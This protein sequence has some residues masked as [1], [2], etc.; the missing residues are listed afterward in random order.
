MSSVL[1]LPHSRHIETLTT[2]YPFGHIDC[3]NFTLSFLNMHIDIYISHASII[4]CPSIPYSNCE[5]FSKPV[6]FTLPGVVNARLTH[7]CRLAQWYS[8]GLLFRWP[9][10]IFWWLPGIF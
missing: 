9:G 7:G 6:S 10:F 1:D 8:L 4:L 2:T 3:Q 5:M